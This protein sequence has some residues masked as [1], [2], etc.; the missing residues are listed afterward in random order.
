MTAGRELDALVAEKV[1]GEKLVWA[2]PVP[3]IHDGRT[4][5][6]TYES[7]DG[8]QPHSYR[9]YEFNIG[10]CYASACEQTTVPDYSSDISA[11]W[12]VVEKLKELSKFSSKN[13]W[14]KFC[15]VIA[16]PWNDCV[17]IAIW[18]LTPELICLAALKAVG[19][20]D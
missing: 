12:A 11:A 2:Y 1:M 14:L 9:T 4:V 17:T 15:D 7:G 5:D 13:P 16:G 8:T 3:L 19:H 6:W 20:T 18:E 10:N